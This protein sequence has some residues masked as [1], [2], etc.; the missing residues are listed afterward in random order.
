MTAPTAPARTLV[1]IHD[2]TTWVP[3]VPY[4]ELTPGRGVPVL[5]GTEQIALYRDTAGRLYALDHRDPFSGAY[6]MARGLLGSRAGVPVVASPM[7]KQ[8]F[9]LRTGECLDEEG[10]PEGTSARL[11]VWPVRTSTGPGLA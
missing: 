4:E 10:G 3:V 8:V 2:G 11:R 1:E 9:D 5:L 7:Y 6:V